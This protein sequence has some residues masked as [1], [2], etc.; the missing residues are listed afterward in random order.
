MNFE[1]WLAAKGF[2]LNSLT[3]KQESA[4]RA[5]F[6]AQQTKTVKAPVATES[7]SLPVAKHATEST[8]SPFQKEMDE[9]ERESKRKSEISRI[10]LEAMKQHTCNPEK[11]EQ[12]RKLGEAAAADRNLSVQQFQLDM[13]RAE[14]FDGQ[15]VYAKSTPEVTPKMIEAALCMSAQRNEG[16][17]KTFDERTLQMANDRFRHGMS[18]CDLLM[19]AAKQNSGFRGSHRDV[20]GMCRAAFN[21][22]GANQDYLASV[23]PST[24]DVD[25]ILSNIANKFLTTSFMFIEQSWREIAAI[26]SVKDFKQITTYRMT[27]DT[28]FEKVN[29]SG[30]IKHGT[31][32]E[33]PYTNQAETY[34]KL[35]GFSRNDIINDDLGAFTGAASHLARGAGDKFNK[36]F[37]LEWLDDSTFFPTDKSLANYDDGATDSVLSLAGLENADAIFAA[38]TK[39]DGSPLGAMPAILLVPRGL[40]A[41]A[42]TLMSATG[43]MGGSTTNAPNSNPWAGM[44]NVVSSLY[45]GNSAITG[46]STTAW[47]LLANPMDIPGIEVVFLNGIQTP[48]VETGEFDFDRLGYAIRA[49]FDFGCNKQEYRCGVK[50]K[51]AA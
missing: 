48:T 34:G 1:Q 35:L 21:K 41:T 29:P 39:E 42:K 12:L 31:L 46:Y 36:V 7:H 47:Y 2:E 16:I 19:H 25:G 28:E 37:W 33:T 51:G 22:R 23:G 8:V 40:Q 11:V 43:L 13:L 45:L 5:D 27:S 4:L 38:Q 14:R 6:D 17:E 10:T 9:I 30:E 32:G 20:L 50:L 3:P 26:R 44:F 18:L 15:L 24:I 49:Y